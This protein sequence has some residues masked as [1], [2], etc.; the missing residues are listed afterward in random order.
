MKT[1]AKRKR[2]RDAQARLDRIHATIDR[3]ATACA[4]AG[5]AFGAV[6]VAG[7]FAINGVK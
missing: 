1:Y 7:M 4:Y 6:L 3:I 5:L 2:E